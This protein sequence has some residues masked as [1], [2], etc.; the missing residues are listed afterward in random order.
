MS[1]TAIIILAGIAAFIIIGVIALSIFIAYK[2]KTHKN[3]GSLDPLN[4]TN[5]NVWM[6]NLHS[7]AATR[8]LMAYY[9]Q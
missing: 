5:P 3:K 4:P 2:R 9:C 6:S 7:T 8:N 1:P